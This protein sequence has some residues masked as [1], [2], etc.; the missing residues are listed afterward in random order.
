MQKRTAEYDSVFKTMKLKHKRL[1]ISV[2]NDVF[3]KEYRPDEEV[4]LLS[5]EG[6]LAEGETRDGSKKMKERI[7]DFLV[8][9]GNEVY[10]LEC[11]SYDDKSMAIRIAEYAFISARKRAEYGIGY[12]NMEMPR[13]AVIYVKGTKNTPR[14][15]KITYTFPDGQVVEY[16]AEN[17][18]LDEI[19]KEYILDKRL[20]PY[21][22]FY[23]TR[24]EK[25]IT[26][27]GDIDSVIKDLEYLK[28]GMLDLHKTGELKDEELLDLMGFVNTII[29]HIT[30]GNQNEERLVEVMGGVVLETKSEQL[31]HKGE[32]KMLIKMGRKYGI[33]ET[34]ILEELQDEVGM[35][36][37][38]AV[39]CLEEYR[40]KG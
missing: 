35:S 8:K 3:E 10:L 29:T 25:V 13:F 27:N 28:K 4:E 12:A 36:L 26:S 21:I 15:T 22:P 37:E 38:Q 1:F 2:I 30:N 32:A 31:I 17:V 18:M 16:E 7:T 19:T 34:E 11:Q 14:T 20:F 6:Y 39:K 33:D 24:Y 40:Q 23:I 5:S 9:I